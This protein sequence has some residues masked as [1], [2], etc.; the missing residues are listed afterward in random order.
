MN[1]FN[2]LQI[3]LISE[4]VSSNSFLI[5]KGMYIVATKPIEGELEMVKI[6]ALNLVT[7]DNDFDATM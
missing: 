3:K 1:F 2:C 5:S 4:I 7:L 6:Y